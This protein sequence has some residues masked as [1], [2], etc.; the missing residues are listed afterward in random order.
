MAE[1][2]K[3]WKVFLTE[4]GAKKVEKLSILSENA[5]YPCMMP[6]IGYGSIEV[7]IKEGPET[8]THIYFTPDEV[9]YANM[10]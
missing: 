2:E 9:A 1:K 5:L 10:C 8:G 3:S 4:R 7:T 6:C